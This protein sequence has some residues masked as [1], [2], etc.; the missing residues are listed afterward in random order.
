MLTLIDYI[1]ALAQHIA[2]ERGWTD[3][4]ALRWVQVRIDEARDEYRQAGA[5]LG[6]TDEGFLAWLLPRHQPPTA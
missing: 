5:P 1:A 4:E 6:N 3:A 2:H